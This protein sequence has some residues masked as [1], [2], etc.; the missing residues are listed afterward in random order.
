MDSKFDNMDS[1][2]DNI[3][4]KL[5]SVNADLKNVVVNMDSKFETQAKL[6]DSTIESRVKPLSD[7][8]KNLNAFVEQSKL[9]FSKMDD[10][11]DKVSKLEESIQAGA[12]ELKNC[13]VELE[14]FKQ[15]TSTTFKEIHSLLNKHAN[16]NTSS[17]LDN[18]NV[19]NDTNSS[20]FKFI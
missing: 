6:F 4:S 10:S 20:P 11:L 18:G 15:T 5:V 8:V 7:K 2:F 12:V 17:S 3:D 1:K 9:L 19:N 16:N 13:V 14:D